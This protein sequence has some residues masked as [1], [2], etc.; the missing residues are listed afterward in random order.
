MWWMGINQSEAS[1]SKYAKL[2]N[3][4]TMDTT[5]GKNSGHHIHILQQVAPVNEQ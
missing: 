3:N 2:C 1:L 4:E 5:Y